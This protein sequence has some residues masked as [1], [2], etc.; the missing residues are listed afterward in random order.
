[1]KDV[2]QK[3]LDMYNPKTSDDEANALKEITQD[4]ALYALY[5]SVFFQNANFIGGT[6]LRILH[7]VDR[8]SEDLAF[9]ATSKVIAKDFALDAYLA[10]SMV[11][12]NAYGYDLSISSSSKKQRDSNIQSHFLKDDSIKKILTFRHAVDLRSKIKIKV[13]IDINPP[14]HAIRRMEYLSFPVDF[15]IMTYD[16][17]SLFAGK[18]HALLCRPYCKGRDLF[19]FL[20]YILNKIIP[21]YKMLAIALFQLGPWKGKKLLSIVFGPKASLV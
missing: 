6:S 3:K 8:F 17:S 2:I 5:K 15:P 19:D 11:H 7:R 1:M 14:D 16:L 13:E 4:V 10:E 21:N 20:W 12:M 18:L 9:S